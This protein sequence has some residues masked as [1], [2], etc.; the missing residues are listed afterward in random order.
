MT[1]LIV[2]TLYVWF[3]TLLFKNN[4]HTNAKVRENPNRHGG[5]KCHNKKMTA[6]VTN[7]KKTFKIQN[8]KAKCKNTK[9]SKTQLGTAYFKLAQISSL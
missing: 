7:E 1:H 8:I 3:F 2:L 4:K 9:H 5:K 6:L